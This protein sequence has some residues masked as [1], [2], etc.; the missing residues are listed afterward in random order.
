MKESFSRRR[1][2]STALAAGM[3][4]ALTS[5][6][7]AL[8][9]APKRLI[10]GTR[11]I[12]V[13]GR[14]TKVFGL[15]GPDGRPGI[16]L[17]G[18]ERFKVELVNESG[19][20]TLVHWHGQL[21]PWTQ[22]GFPWPQTPPILNGAVQTYDYAPIP[23]TYWMHSH[24][25]MQEQSLMTAPLI[26][27]TVAELRE[28]RQEVVLILHDFTFRTPEEV[29][30]GLTGTSPA[31]AQLTARKIEEAPGGKGGSKVPATTMVNMAPHGPRMAMPGMTMSR[32]AGMQMDLNDVSYDAFLANDRTLADPEI[33]HVERDGRI[34][35]RV[36]NGA[37]SSQFWIDLGELV[38]H[39][40]ATD[41]HPVH[42]V[43]GSRFPIA[44]AQRLDILIDLP[45]AGAFP[46]LAQLEGE[47]RQ[48]G[49]VLATPGAPIPQIADRTQ[50]A[51]PVDN[52]LE[53]RLA[54]VE[55]LPPRPAD[56]VQT[57]SLSGSMTP[58]AWS[59]NGEYWP[60]VTP[61]MLSE[62]QRIEIDL[63]NHSMMAH[64][65]HLHGHAF[66][67]IAIDGR[68]INGA[69]RDTVLVMPMSRVRIAFDANNPGRWPFHC[70]NLYH[71]ATGMMTE[72]RYR[73]IIT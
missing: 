5:A 52:S 69:V 54:A 29:L 21:P 3:S 20:R 66:Q 11:L 22:D 62:G 8:P 70:H 13:N 46:I 68:K 44:M 45:R 65:M 14:S 36:I 28:D 4:P 71:M 50:A 19:T 59:M 58:Y 51:P 2:L 15:T 63:I 27:H 47:G 26:V 56:I 55:P 37:S 10:A 16:R 1:F 39:V 18:G 9:S 43:A 57:I 64:P 72:F 61:L 49:I 41:G 38:G 42:P 67:L 12:E 23:G 17:A 60:H 25:E 31:A 7:R 34:R 35:L 33:V 48:T 53:V 6:A 24:H 32:P 73:G 40:V 30:A